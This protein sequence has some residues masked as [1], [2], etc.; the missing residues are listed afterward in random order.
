LS[1]YLVGGKALVDLF[2][3]V[4]AG[5]V[6]LDCIK[7]ENKAATPQW[8]KHPLPDDALEIVPPRNS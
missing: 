6:R 2:P 4:S 3:G 8:G 1:N 5:R 7:F